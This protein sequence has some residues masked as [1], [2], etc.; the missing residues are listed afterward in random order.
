MKMLSGADRVADLDVGA[1]EGADGQGAV[2]RELHVA[3]ARGL[4]PGG[5]DLLGEVA[6][7]DDA[8]GEADIVVRDEGDLQPIADLGI[9]VHHGRHVVDELDD[10]LGALIG[11]RCLAGEDLDPWLPVGLRLALIAA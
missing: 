10:Q 2:E 3:R 5:A 1:I 7:R 11:G 4:H 9:G 8:L 6:R